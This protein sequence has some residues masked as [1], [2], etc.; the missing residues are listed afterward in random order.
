METQDYIFIVLGA[1]AIVLLGHYVPSL[2]KLSEPTTID[3]VQGIDL[4]SLEICRRN[5]LM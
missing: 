2:K 1:L 3:Q 5:G 4:K